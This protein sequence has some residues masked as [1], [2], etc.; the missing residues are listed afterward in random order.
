M[1][2]SQIIIILRRLKVVRLRRRL[3]RLRRKWSETLPKSENCL[4]RK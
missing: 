1:R 4:R 3:L 2:I